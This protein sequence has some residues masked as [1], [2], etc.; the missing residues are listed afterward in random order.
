M[1]ENI[2]EFQYKYFKTNPWEMDMCSVIEGM[3]GK[4]DKWDNSL[5]K[6]VMHL[7]DG[8][9]RK[10][11]RG[12][13]IPDTKKLPKI[14][15]VTA[16]AAIPY[17]IAIKECWQTAYSRKSSPKFFPIDV[18]RKRSG[19]QGNKRIL[20]DQGL[21]QI[22][23]AQI[24]KLKQIGEKHGAFNDTAVFDEYVSTGDTLKKVQ[25]QLLEAGFNNVNFMYG[26]WGHK[27]SAVPI[28]E[29]ARPIARKGSNLPLSERETIPYRPLAIQINKDSKD[30]INDMKAIGKEMGKQILKHT[31]EHSATQ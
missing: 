28:I 1:S 9:Q 7:H 3:I 29:E 15:F 14:L 21:M 31:G 25:K 12:E 11:E 5:A 13:P 18:S 30:L 8:V 17:A 19:L 24:E 23:L 4:E 6:A 27:F 26:N 22:D 20:D 2:P 10:N 16:T